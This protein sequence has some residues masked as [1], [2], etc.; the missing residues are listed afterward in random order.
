LPKLSWMLRR[1]EIAAAAECDEEVEELYVMLIHEERDASIIAAAVKAMDDKKTAMEQLV[2]L[3]GQSYFSTPQT[4]MEGGD[5]L[6]E[7]K[8]TRIKGKSKKKKR[9][10][11]ED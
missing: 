5:V 8:R 9:K 10:Q 1:I 3:H 11:L 4:D 7:Q 6:K 2:K